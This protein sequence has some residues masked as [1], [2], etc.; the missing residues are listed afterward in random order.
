M[1]VFSERRKR[2]D[3]PWPRPTTQ[4]A[5]IKALT[6]PDGD[7]DGGW[8]RL[9]VTYTDQQGVTERHAS[10]RVSEPIKIQVGDLSEPAPAPTLSSSATSGAVVGS[11]LSVNNPGS[12]VEWQQQHGTGD[13]AYWKTIATSNGTLSHNVGS[14][15]CGVTRR[16]LALRRATVW[17]ATTVLEVNG[18]R[19]IA[20]VLPNNNADYC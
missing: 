6:L 7:G 10:D 19:E 11:T 8:Y 15:G 3:G 14:R 4:T 12:K 2:L 9:V 13:G 17:T 18:G 16:G 5:A 1:G 20:A